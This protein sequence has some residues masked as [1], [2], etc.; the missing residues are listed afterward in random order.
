MRLG[1]SGIHTACTFLQEQCKSKRT[2]NKCG[3]FCAKNVLRFLVRLDNFP[4]LSE[5][6]NVAVIS[7]LR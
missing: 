4:V 3:L 5:V 7:T 6:S 2:V 1:T